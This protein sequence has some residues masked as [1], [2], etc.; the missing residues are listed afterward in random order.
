MCKDQS[1]DIYSAVSSFRHTNTCPPPCLPTCLIADSRPSK[2][3]AGR[4]IPHPC[5]FTGY[6]H[7]AKVDALGGMEVEFK[8]TGDSVACRSLS[9]QL[10]N[11][12]VPCLT[13]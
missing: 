9:R 3:L 7:K 1:I 8:G 11:L 12:Q 4:V 10:L 5:F 6:N 13:E 2:I